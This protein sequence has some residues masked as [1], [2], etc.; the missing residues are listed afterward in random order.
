MHWRT[1]DIKTVGAW[2]LGFSVLAGSALTLIRFE[3]RRQLETSAEQ[4]ALQWAKFAEQ[5]LPEMEEI[6]PGELLTPQTRQQLL[7]LAGFNHVF[8]FKMFDRTGQQILDSR[9][10]FQP[11]GTTLPLYKEG[12]GTH[13]EESNKLPIREAV[14]SGKTVVTLQRNTGPDRPDVYSEAYVPVMRA[15]VVQGVVEV[16]VDQ[17]ALA[18]STRAGFA[19]VTALVGGFL[20]L[21]M[22]IAAYHS[23]RRLHVARAAKAKFQELAHVDPLTGA[24][25]RVS[26]NEVIENA[27]ARHAKGGPAFALICIDLDNF[28]EIND[29]LGHAA[30]DQALREATKRIQDD[31]R[32]GDYVARLGGDEFAVLM[33]GVDKRALVATLA[34]RMVQSLAKPLVLGSVHFNFGGSAGIALFGQDANTPED[35][36]VRADLAMYRAKQSARG[37]F[38]FYDL[39][40]DVKLR[41]RRELTRD[42][43]VAVEGDQLELYYQPLYE[44]DADTLVGYEALLRWHHPTRGMISPVEF[45][46]LAEENGLIG[47]IGQWALARACEDA[48]GWP[49]SLTVQVNLSPAQFADTKLVQHILGILDKTGL[50]AQRLGLEV[51]ESL[52]INNSEQ[53]TKV[54]NELTQAG[55]SLAMDDFGTGYSSLAYLWRFPFAKV[56]IDRAFTTHLATNPKVAVI[57]RSII[58]MAHALDIR[59]NAE[60][61]ETDA[62]MNLL[63]TCGCD[64]L[65]GYALGMPQP[66]GA[67]THRGHVPARTGEA[68]E[69]RPR[70]SLFAGLEVSFP[71]SLP[72]PL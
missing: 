19:R 55:I 28:K 63:R 39:E 2:V 30:G 61:V 41:S 43:A 16:Y 46:S 53:I 14:L 59:V 10:V 71:H 8:L 45:I 6:R 40:M 9:D 62:Q 42:L 5:T 50:P 33:M 23:W 18:M 13:H 44:S 57:V 70:E 49:A 15:G 64:E 37:Y 3:S 20:L 68:Y 51:T 22:A 25:N 12:V 24:L 4:M 72:S 7:K 32:E 35:L 26:F 36:L 58:S 69:N 48:L 1:R 52:L 65:Q 21:F 34:H 47:T 67:L 11:E 56:K 27:A 38:T 31:V 66:N 54:L 17:S 60:G 29:T